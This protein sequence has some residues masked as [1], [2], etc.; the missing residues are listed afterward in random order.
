MFDKTCRNILLLYT[1]GVLSND[2]RSIY[3]IG[4]FF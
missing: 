4:Y 3:L 1:G 2:F